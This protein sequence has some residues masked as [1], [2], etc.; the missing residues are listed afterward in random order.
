MHNNKAYTSS[1]NKLRYTLCCVALL[2][3]WHTSSVHGYAQEYKYELGGMLGASCYLGD[4]NPRNPM[5]SVGI[6]AHAVARYNI[7]FRFVVGASAGYTQLRGNSHNS[8]TLFPQ[9]VEGSFNTSTILLN[10]FVE[11]NFYPYSD[12]FSYLRTK[13]LVPYISLGVAA[14]VGFNYQNK[15]FFLPA[16]SGALGL[17]YKVANRWNVQLQLAGMHFFADALESSSKAGSAFNNPLGTS[18]LPWKGGDGMVALWLG[19]TYEFGMHKRS[20]NNL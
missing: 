10:P 9:S 18:K 7:D 19:V 5:R 17:K 6:S 11:Y 12:K 16:I 2:A 3:A 8:G 14:G 1:Y 15:P 4:A 13:R 20:C